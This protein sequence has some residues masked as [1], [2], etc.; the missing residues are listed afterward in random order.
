MQESNNEKNFSKID[1]DSVKIRNSPS[2]KGRKASSS[3]FSHSDILNKH[4]NNN[5]GGVKSSIF[6][7]SGIGKSFFQKMRNEEKLNIQTE[8]SNYQTEGS[9]ESKNSK[10]NI[11]LEIKSSM[12]LGGKVD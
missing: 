4:F 2:M 9:Q 12:N 11:D 5:E 8:I 6:K 1:S 3:D 10:N 7:P